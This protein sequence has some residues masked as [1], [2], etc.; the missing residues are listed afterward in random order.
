[1]GQLDD[2]E[3]LLKPR[4]RLYPTVRSTLLP[5]FPIP[6]LK[7]DFNT[8]IQVGYTGSGSAGTGKLVANGT[9]NDKITLTSQSGLSTD[10]GWYGIQFYDGTSSGSQV[11]YTTIEYAGGNYD[12]AIVGE[13]VMPAGLVTL[14]HVD[15]KNLVQP[16]AIGISETA[17]GAEFVVTN[18]TRDGAPYTP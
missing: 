4:A 2:G 13:S 14:D 8:A 1:M 5:A 9:A 12:A 3:A 7:F 15:I 16:G 18:C 11:T 17:P 6:K 10:E